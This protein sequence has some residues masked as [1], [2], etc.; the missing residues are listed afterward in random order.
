MNKLEL[1]GVEVELLEENDKIILKV[2][3]DCEVR[4]E[5][6]IKDIPRMKEEY[7]YLPAN[8]LPLVSKYEEFI[9]EDEGRLDI[10]LYIKHSNVTL[11]IKPNS[12][13]FTARYDTSED[14]ALIK[15]KSYNIPKNRLKEFK[16]TYETMNKL[17]NEKGYK[18]SY[19]HSQNEFIWCYSDLE[20]DIES[21]NEKEFIEVSNAIFNHDKA[22]KKLYENLV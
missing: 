6:D 21:F 1:K 17:L 4:R 12:K 13:T 3:G 9:S 16:E 22:I 5:I 11:F 18:L 15:I 2:K 20:F 14:N 10:D 19:S 8:L 7:K